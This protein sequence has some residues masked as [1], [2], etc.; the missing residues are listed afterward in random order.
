[1]NRYSSKGSSFKD[2]TNENI[3]LFG[4]YKTIVRQKF[5]FLFLSEYFLLTSQPKQRVNWDKLHFGC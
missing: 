3:T 4:T 1:M 2:L 5:D